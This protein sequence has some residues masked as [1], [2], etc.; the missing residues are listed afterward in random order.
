MFSKTLHA[1]RQVTVAIP[2]PL[3]GLATNANTQKVGII[4]VP[5]SKGAKVSGVQLGPKAIRD[6]GLVKEI[7]DF[8]PDVDIKDYG[9]VPEVDVELPTLPKNMPNYQTVVG[10]MRNL[11]QRV[12]EVLNEGRTCITLGGDHTIAIG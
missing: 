9:D 7:N 12:S 3:R 6:A 1:L 10:T 8:H 5:F 2:L 11:S 4:G